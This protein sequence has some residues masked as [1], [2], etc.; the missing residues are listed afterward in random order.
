[1]KFGIKPILGLGIY[2]VK[3][4]AAK[5]VSLYLPFLVITITLKP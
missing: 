3:H 5:S 2:L 1:M 4:P